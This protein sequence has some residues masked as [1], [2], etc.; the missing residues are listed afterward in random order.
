[1]PCTM[2]VNFF[3]LIKI[4]RECGGNLT[5]LCTYLCINNRI[6]YLCSKGIVAYCRHYTD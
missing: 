3:I 2:R 1:M 4:T 5:L 6:W